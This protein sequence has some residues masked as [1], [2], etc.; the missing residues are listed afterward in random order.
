MGVKE[1]KVK[2][3]VVYAT[4]SGWVYPASRARPV[5]EGNSARPICS[6]NLKPKNLSAPRALITFLLP[7]FFL[8]FSLPFYLC[9]RESSAS[10]GL[11]LFPPLISLSRQQLSRFFDN[12][13]AQGRIS[14]GLPVGRC[15]GKNTHAQQR[16]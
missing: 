15:G 12:F 5:I 14:I 10:S 8:S 3:R 16:R 6:G 7:C 1:P 11:T 13:R 9:P 2:V 4:T